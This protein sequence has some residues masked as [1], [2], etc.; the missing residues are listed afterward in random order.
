MRRTFIRTDAGNTTSHLP[1]TLLVVGLSCIAIAMVLCLGPHLCFRARKEQCAEHLDRLWCVLQMYGDD[2]DGAYPP[3]PRSLTPLV[4]N[5]EVFACP[6]SENSSASVITSLTDWA[7]YII[8]HWPNGSH[9]V[10]SNYPVMYDRRLSHHSG[11]GVNVLYGNGRV[12]W[13]PGA[14]NLRAFARKHSDVLIQLP[15]GVRR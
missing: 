3:D 7:D 6:G 11:K 1:R 14:Q 13:D 5:P 10:P 15:E 8:I 9:H 2:N 4:D 12:V